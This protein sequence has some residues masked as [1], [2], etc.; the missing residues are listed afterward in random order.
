MDRKRIY[1]W[2]IFFLGSLVLP[3]PWYAVMAA[4][5]APLLLFIYGSIAAIFS[6]DLDYI[7]YV[8]FLPINAAILY[9]ISHLLT[10]RLL[11]LKPSVFIHVALIAT[12]TALSFVPWHSTLGVN[13]TETYSTIGFYLYMLS[14]FAG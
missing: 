13:G 11:K 1:K 10:K 7:I 6:T 4:G 14:V 9:Y 2:E 3:V 12:F 8:I 5:T